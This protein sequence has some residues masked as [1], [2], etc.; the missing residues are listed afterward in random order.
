MQFLSLLSKLEQALM[1]IYWDI[2]K[3]ITCYELFTGVNIIPNP[4]PMGLGQKLLFGMENEILGQQIKFMK[5][6]GH[7]MKF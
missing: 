3:C 7:K 4:I 5:L 2:S 6:L 1:N